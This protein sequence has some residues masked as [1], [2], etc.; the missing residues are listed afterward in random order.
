M[1]GATRRSLVPGGQASM[2]SRHSGGWGSAVAKQVAVKNFGLVM[3]S[4]VLRLAAGML[5]MVLMARVFGRSQF[6]HFVYWMAIA[7]LVTVPVNFGL[8]TYVLREI[9]I[10][11]SRYHPVMA[12]ALTAKL[13]IAGAVL[14]CS[15]LA[16]ALLPPA[17]ALVFGLLVLAQL[18]DSFGE[19]FNL[20][21]RRDGQFRA[22]ALTAVATSLLHLA[23]MG[24]AI[25]LP[26]TVL[27]AAAAFALSRAI[28]LLLLAWR[29]MAATGVVRPAPLR[30]VAPLLRATLAYG[31]ELALFTA[32][33]QA[34]TLLVN[35][36]LGSAGVGLYQAGMKLVDGICR[37]APVLAQFVLPTL[38]SRQGDPQAF[39]RA[40][41]GVMGLMGG[42]GLA[43]AALLWAGAGAITHQLYGPQYSALQALL[44]LFGAVL[45]LRFLE[46]GVGL[47]L[48]AQ[49]QQQ[50]KVWLVALQLLLVIS[51]GYPALQH[52]GLVGWQLVV[53]AGLV[54]VL[55][56][57][58]LL[59]RR[60]LVPVQQPTS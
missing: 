42:I 17:D 29:S 6:G 20:G 44:P 13:L 7:T 1:A 36:V 34:D 54:L 19:F 37:L 24:L 31:G 32:Y 23:L 21:F 8:G 39:R 56:L 10:H 49:G 58:G 52:F 3:L 55:V 16:C 60:A 59:C 28:G 57:Y 12:A 9:G 43:G 15:A 38:S 48:V 25:A 30:S 47:I 14:A 50:R 26:G 46:T 27:W 40:A 18:F 35:S 45:L 53:I 22:E 5:V 4:F 33:S 11:R 51:A 2:T 41:W